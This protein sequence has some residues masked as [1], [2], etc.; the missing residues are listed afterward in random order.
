MSRYV[1]IAGCGRLGSLLAE[2]LSRAGD[3][4]VVID[5]DE[6]RFARLSSDFSGFRIHGDATELEVLRQAKADRADALIAATSLDNVN[7][8]VAQV[9]R[10]VFHV[11]VVVARVFNPAREAIYR[12]LGLRV[13]C[14]TKLSANS[15]L[16]ALQEEE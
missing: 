14:P 10:V 13:V 7:L 1:I 5:K 8:M 2:E 4:V 12:R 16:A 15:F 9:A 3:S 11:P 6:S